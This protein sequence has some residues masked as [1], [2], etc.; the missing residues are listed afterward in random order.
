M[1]VIVMNYRVIW[2]DYK[3]LHLRLKLALFLLKT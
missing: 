3:V 2:Y 1:Y